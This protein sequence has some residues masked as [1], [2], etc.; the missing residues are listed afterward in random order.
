MSSLWIGDILGLTLLTR[1]LPY[2]SA[3][4]L[5]SPRTKI[6]MK[7][8]KNRN[9]VEY[10]TLYLQRSIRK[11]TF[12]AF[13]LWAD[14]LAKKLFLFTPRLHRDSCS[15]WFFVHC[16]SGLSHVASNEVHF[17]IWLLQALP[18]STAIRQ[19]SA[20]L[21]TCELEFSEFWHMHSS[22]TRGWDLVE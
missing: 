8:I 20:F 18:F 4:M 3:S 12:P 21:Y 19:R 14:K 15:K 1:L 2:F 5:L 22:W 13:H 17:S 7:V 9:W 6:W 11:L 16:I 10:C